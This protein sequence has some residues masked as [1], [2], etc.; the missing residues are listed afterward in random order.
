M[1]I[2][3]GESLACSYLRHVEQC[4]LVQSNWKVSEHWERQASDAE[5]ESLFQEMRR[6]F[7]RNGG[8]FK[9]TSGAAQFL[10][11]GEID[12]VGINQS[13]EVY[14]IEAAFHEAGLNYGS[15][16]ETDSRVLKKML[17]T[18]LILRAYLPPET[19]L[20]IYFLSP[21]INPV[22]Q[23]P[24]ERTFEELGKAYPAVEWRLV[25]NGAF[26]ERV[27]QA[28][29]E[30][31]SSVADT[32][33]L[34]IRS[35]KLLELTAPPRE[36]HRQAV[37][38]RKRP[39]RA[40]DD[41]PTGRLQP[42]AQALMHT[43]LNERPSLLDEREQRNLTDGDYCKT[44]LHLRIGNCALLRHV[45]HGT[46]IHGHPRYYAQPYG[47]YYL[48]SQWGK[49]YHAHNA[50]S[51]LNFVRALQVRQSANPDVPALARHEQALRDYL[52]A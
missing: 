35:A 43:L 48:C 28:T 52:G 11:Q 4:W 38:T 46:K 20:H 9:Q 33:E 31:A 13:R 50:E 27:V 45:E 23:Q 15:T 51:L 6:R 34:F 8:V 36:T 26:N 37:P 1:K 18:L 40:T 17:R 49:N 2:E 42:I 44:Q 3:I 22:V 12:V 16:A 39:N 25:S 24:L 7:G 5:T 41:S 19:P 14:A 10:K 32:S 47:A 29:L 21:R 30:K